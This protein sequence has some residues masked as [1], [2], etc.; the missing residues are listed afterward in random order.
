MSNQVND[1]DEGLNLVM[2]AG[3]D[4]KRMRTIIN[5]TFSSSKLK[6]VNEIL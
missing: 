4:W 6:E 1:K 2:S 5:P 3:T